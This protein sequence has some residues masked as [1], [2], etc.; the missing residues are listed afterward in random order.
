MIDGL[1]ECLDVM[2]SPPAGWFL[3]PGMTVGDTNFQ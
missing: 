2:F 1:T 3:N